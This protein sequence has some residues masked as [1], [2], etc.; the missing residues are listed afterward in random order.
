MS[1]VLANRECAIADAVRYAR[2]RPER[3]LLYQAVE[4]HYPAFI[5]ELQSQGN[6]LPNY[7][8]R[9][10]DDLLKCGEFILPST[11]QDPAPEARLRLVPGLVYEMTG[12]VLP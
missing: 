11:Q 1:A 8:Q 5:A 4:R 9:D 6:A 7:V 3:T 2:R 10:F 12:Q